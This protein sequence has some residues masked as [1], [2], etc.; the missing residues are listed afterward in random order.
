MVVATVPVI[1]VDHQVSSVKQA[2]PD[3]PQ[4]A[5]CNTRVRE[6]TWGKHVPGPGAHG[7]AS[8]VGIR[9]TA[10]AALVQE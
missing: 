9:G 2:V 7:A 6:L 10:S 1:V 4:Q 8:C 5:W 3:L